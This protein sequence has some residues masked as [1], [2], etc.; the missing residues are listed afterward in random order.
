MEVSPNYD[1]PLDTSGEE[2]AGGDKTRAGGA[3]GEDGGAGQ[4]RDFW[5]FQTIGLQTNTC[6]SWSGRLAVRHFS[7]EMNWRRG[8]A[9]K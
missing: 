6:E 4:G 3:L 8:I 7:A 2:E 1:F 5:G 9:R